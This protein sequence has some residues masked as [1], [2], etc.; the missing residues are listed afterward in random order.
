L[1]IVKEYKQTTAPLAI[2]LQGTQGGGVNFFAG[3]TVGAVSKGEVAGGGS[4]WALNVNC[5]IPRHWMPNNIKKMPI[6]KNIARHMPGASGKE[7]IVLLV[8]PSADFR[9]SLNYC[10]KNA[11]CNDKLQRR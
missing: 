9:I 4:S 10:R 1:G 8:L 11:T 6:D 7:E 2:K 3:P 5:W